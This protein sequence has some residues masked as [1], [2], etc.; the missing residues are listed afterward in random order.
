VMVSWVY[1]EFANDRATLAATAAG[2]HVR[3]KLVML[4]LEDSVDRKCFDGVFNDT[5]SLLDEAK[6]WFRFRIVNA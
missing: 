3:A 4:L 2:A 6:L 1:N 5:N